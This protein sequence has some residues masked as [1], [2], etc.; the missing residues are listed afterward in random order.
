M[1]RAAIALLDYWRAHP[2]AKDSAKG[3]AQYWVSEAADTVY[4]ALTLLVEEGVI[5]RRRHLYQLAS[6][7]ADQDDA[8]IKNLEKALRR[9]RSRNRGAR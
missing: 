5:E 7:S 8:K 3:I 9:L 6:S 2:Q 1:L 4:Q